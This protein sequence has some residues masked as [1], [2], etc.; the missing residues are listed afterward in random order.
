MS[1]WVRN[2]KK[3]GYSVH[4]AGVPILAFH[5]TTQNADAWNQV[6]EACPTS[7]QW[8]T[9]EFPGSGESAMPTA[10]I[11]L[12]IM[13]DDAVALMHELGHQKF[14][15]V[16]YSLGAVAALQCAAT[17]HES[18]LSITSLCGWS[19]S[20]ARMKITF[21]LWRR[22][23]AIDSE[24]FMRYALADGYTAAG[25]EALEPMIDMVV[26]M[27]AST[28]QP[29]SD[30]HLELDLRINIEDS[31]AHITAP[32]LVIGGLEDRWVDISKSRHIAQ[33]IPGSQL[34]ELPAGHLV[35]GECASDV[36][37][38]ISRHISQI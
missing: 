30:A 22:L 5:G 18:V 9:F 8:V 37:T 13:I 14:H 15:V 29:G 31:L 11:E 2:G 23:I 21:D 25:L 38:A 26:P 17:Q 35:I 1:N 10:P 24:L 32:C 12:D 16:G 27:A 34:L 4:G 6:R 7:F 28:V 36:A 3:I 20:D 33:S 19:V